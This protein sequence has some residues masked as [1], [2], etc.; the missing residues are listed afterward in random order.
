MN[1]R[2][3]VKDFVDIVEY[4]SRAVPGITL[5]TDIIVGFPYET[6]E[7]YRA[8]MALL[9]DLDLNIVHYAR[10]YP[11]PHTVAARYEQLPKDVVKRRVK[12]LSDWFKGLDPYMPLVG[13]YMPVW[14]SNERVNGSRSCHT[15]EYIKVLV[16]DSE[17]YGDGDVLLVQT[18]AATRFHLNAKVVSSLPSCLKCSV[19]PQQ[20]VGASV[21]E[22]R[23]FF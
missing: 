8:T 19:C 3:E 23:Q 17:A 7:D 12:E 15:K 4:L 1:R 18:T 16:E 21:D 5:S 11:R 13:K 20:L 6:E 22:I 9:K 10:Y 2:Y 14:V